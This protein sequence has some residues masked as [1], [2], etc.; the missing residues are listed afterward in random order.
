[1]RLLNETTGEV[2]NG[3]CHATNLCPYC[4]RRFAAETTEALVIDGL[5]R[6]VVHDLGP[7]FICVRSRP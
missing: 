3:R 4:A 6:A 5:Q 2:V 7:L 1:M